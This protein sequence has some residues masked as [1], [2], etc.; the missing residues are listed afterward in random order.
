MGHQFMFFRNILGAFGIAVWL[1]ACAGVGVIETSN[2]REKVAQAGHLIDTGRAGL[3][4]RLLNEAVEIYQRDKNDPAGLAEAYRQY[5]FLARVGGATEGVILIRQPVPVFVPDGLELSDTYFQRALA[6]FTEANRLDMATN[7]LMQLS[8]NAYFRKDIPQ[9]C[10]YLDKAVETNRV[11]QT[12]NPGARIELPKGM[13]TFG[14]LIATMK[15]E[16]GCA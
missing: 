6:T 7:V 2:P 15:K 13:T 4:R 1:S 16:T 10:V 5:A 3:A 14:E 11:W 8:N 12:Q 9:A